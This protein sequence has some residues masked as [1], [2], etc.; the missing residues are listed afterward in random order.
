MRYPVI[1]NKTKYGYDAHC[2]MLPGCHSQG[3][4]L[5]EATENIKDAIETYLKMVAE[6]T[7]GANVYEVEISAYS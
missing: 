6:E 3:D 5:K 4:T 2:P 1:I 7:K